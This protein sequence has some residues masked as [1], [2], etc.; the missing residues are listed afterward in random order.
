[1]YGPGAG[2]G[3]IKGMDAGEDVGGHLQM[4]QMNGQEVGALGARYIQCGM[5]RSRPGA[6]G[7]LLGVV[8]LEGGV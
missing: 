6:G 7:G 5:A 3:L 4:R 8:K 2:G 1:M